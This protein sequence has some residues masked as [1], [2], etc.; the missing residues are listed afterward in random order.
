MTYYL[1]IDIGASSGRHILGWLEDGQLRTREVYRFD[2]NAGVKNGHL[3]WD[4][5]AIYAALIAG[6]KRCGETGMIPYSLGI[7]TWGVDFVLIDSAGSRLGDAVCYRDSRTDG[8]DAEIEKII[9]YEELY[10][11]TG[12]AKQ[13]FNTIYQLTALKKE[14]PQ[15]LEKA[16][17]L[18]MMPDYL[19]YLLS[20]IGSNEYTQAS[21][22]A[23]VDARERNWNRHIIN[24]LGFPERLFR[25][26]DTAGDGIGLLSK[27]VEAEAGFSCRITL[28]ATHDT[29]S[30]FL[31]VPASEDS[32]YISSGTW[33]LL[34][35]ESMA[36]IITRE[37]READFTN[38]GG[39]QYR[40]R[41]LKNIMGLWMVQSVRKELGKKQ[42]FNEL[43]Q[44][45]EDTESFSTV[46]DVNNQAFFAPQSMIE[47]VKEVAAETGQTPPETTGELMQCLYRSLA[48][49]YRDAILNLERIA[50]KHFSSVNLVGGGSKDDYLNR[51]TSRFT[52][53][54]VYAGPIEATVAGNLIVQMI[55]SGELSDLA[56]ARRIV[57]Q[58]FDVKRY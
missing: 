47:A 25:N 15:L 23:L 27:A 8:M 21:T 36:S 57:A 28:P 14:S 54:P 55:S 53:L 9:P 1:A 45:A 51:L 24:A 26:L 29:G 33:S 6:L 44:T 5:D 20:G 17:R 35:I 40:Y 30:A 34:G 38:E 18:L 10:N 43:A 48:V 22:G 4:I 41:F 50:G 11:L 42:S 12:I 56:A 19:H 32:V 31:A 13:P 37:A 16:E 39:F 58:S 3:C 7:D 2:N 46:V 49:S 52:G